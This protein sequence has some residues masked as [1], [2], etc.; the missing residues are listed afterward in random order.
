MK[1]F[2]CRM[3]KYFLSFLVV[4][5]GSVMLTLFHYWGWLDGAHSLS[6]NQDNTYYLHPIH[7]Y[8][9]EH[10]NFFDMPMRNWLW[11]L[12]TYHQPL[13]GVYY[14]F[15]FLWTDIWGTPEAAVVNGQ[16]VTVFHAGV[17]G[18]GMAFFAYV[19]GVRHWAALL[20][21]AVLISSSEMR[22]ISPWLWWFASYSWLPWVLAGIVLVL[23]GK[24]PFLGVFIAA[25][26]FALSVTAQPNI[27]IVYF[28]AVIIFGW[29]INRYKQIH[30]I[31]AL[32]PKVYLF[33]LFSL[34]AILFSG[35]MFWM[36]VLHAKEY[37]RWSSS[38]PIIG[39]FLI[40]F[41][42]SLLFPA[43]IGDLLNV[44]MPTNER[45]AVGN[46][47]LGPFV[48]YLAMYG[49]WARW[50]IWYVPPLTFLCIYSLL[51]TTG[52]TFGLAYINYLLPMLGNSLR[53]LPVYLAIFV[54]SAASLSAIGLNALID[55][56]N[57]NNS[58][59]N[60]FDRFVV[61]LL[62]V[63]LTLAW[64]RHGRVDALYFSIY[65]AIAFLVLKLGLRYKLP[66]YVMGPILSIL[67]VLIAKTS[68]VQFCEV[69]PNST[70]QGLPQNWP[71]RSVLKEIGAGVKDIREYRLRFD[72][73]RDKVADHSSKDPRM[74]GSQSIYYGIPTF[75]YYV[76]PMPY[77]NFRYYIPVSWEPDHHNYLKIFGGKY[78]LTDKSPPDNSYKLV[79]AWQNC[80]LYSTDDALPK[81]RLVNREAGKY[82]SFEEF[83]NIVERTNDY[84]DGVYLHV[85]EAG[86][87]RQW[88]PG[89]GDPGDVE[90][91]SQG[92][93]RIGYY[94]RANTP[95][96]LIVNEHFDK[97]WRANVDGQPVEP[98]EVNLSQVAIPVE[99]GNHNV[100]LTYYP[101][102]F[103]VTS[104]VQLVS[105]IVVALLVIVVVLT[106]FY[107]LKRKSCC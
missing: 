19:M 85:K 67:V 45:Y 20:A 101:A 30:S 26:S 84:K 31:A 47:F 94:V 15:Y 88:L 81:Q 39:S 1:Y 105:L 11:N 54:V 22:M 72:L 55:D 32:L 12:P 5:V 28:S 41:K 43:T 80:S 66:T 96:L 57:E 68:F 93:N 37:I 83:R 87:L 61:P 10:F 36:P 58:V 7:H 8:I 18:V 29:A 56:K 90:R 78:L 82:G 65:T 102:D 73:K 98:V 53:E 25:I 46:S 76:S 77:D 2:D 3:E 21:A 52:K 44:L 75:T 50:R 106:H 97:A 49:I 74:L 70:N 14:P 4:V 13:F 33:G 91:V 38:G 86:R 48:V 63:L 23:E 69:V 79:R 17:F 95:S 64:L 107:K 42:D 40:P 6:I 60:R 99:R 100:E 51:S 89:I 62:G 71:Y 59:F 35:E 9:S 34:L 16:Y 24:R 103:V 27:H 104:W 92:N